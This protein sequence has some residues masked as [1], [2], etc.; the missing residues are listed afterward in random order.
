MLFQNVYV[1]FLIVFWSKS[2]RRL[3]PVY[4]EESRHQE[5]AVHSN[6]WHESKNQLYFRL[7]GQKR[8][9]WKILCQR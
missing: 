8:C 3:Y 6:P 5:N 9:S 1:S 2:V 7:H 4:L